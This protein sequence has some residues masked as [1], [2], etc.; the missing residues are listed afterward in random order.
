M[1]RVEATVKKKERLLDTAKSQKDALLEAEAVKLTEMV[2][3]N[4]H[5]TGKLVTTIKKCVTQKQK[6]E[7]IFVFVF[8]YI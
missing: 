3:K 1:S 6:I 7:S 8:N 5:L 2:K 4:A